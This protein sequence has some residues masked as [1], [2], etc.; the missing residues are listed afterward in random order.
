MAESRTRVLVVDDEM[1]VRQDA[2]DLLSRAGIE[3]H[4]F[5]SA[6]EVL[7]YLRDHSD[8]TAAVFTDIWMES[9][10]E[11]VELARAI[12]ARWPWI[13]LIVTSGGTA[14]P[15]SGLPHKARYISKPWR[16]EQLLRLVQKS[17]PTAKLSSQAA[18]QPAWRAA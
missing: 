13:A 2:L 14:Q 9:A 7:A 15:P 12:H 11:G 18:S 1:L 3:V 16:P 10:T 17:V 5:S 6:A 4:G 8:E